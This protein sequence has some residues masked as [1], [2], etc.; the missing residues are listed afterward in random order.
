[1]KNKKLKK[2]FFI[3]ISFVLLTSLSYAEVVKKIIIKGNQRVSNETIKV[4][5]SI[6]VGD[7]IT[8]DKLNEIVDNLYITN[9]F[10]NI[11]TNF[12]NQELIIKVDESPIINK[13]Q[14]KGIKSKTLIES[15]RKNLK[16]KSRSSYNKFLVE[17]DKF[18]IISDLKNRG[19]YY[20]TIEVFKELQNNN[21]INFH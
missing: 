1:M 15:I 20:S 9:F 12:E 2:I 16:L 5:S 3:I 19:Y 6:K 8:T 7:E 18:Q 13:I 11:S 4:F 10:D 17:T 14:F 21:S